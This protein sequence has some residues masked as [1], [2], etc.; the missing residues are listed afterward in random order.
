MEKRIVRLEFG[1]GDSVLVETEVD[2]NEPGFVRANAGDVAAKALIKMQEAI[3][4]VAKTA[5]F[6]FE[7]LSAA[8]HPPNEIT[9]EFSIKFSVKGDV[10]IARGEAEGNCKLILKWKP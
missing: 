8:A 7:R 10:I 2:E 4:P 5:D 1:D 6:I 3:R 9:T